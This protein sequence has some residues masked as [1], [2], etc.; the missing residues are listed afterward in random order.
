MSSCICPGYEAVFEC[1]VTGGGATIWSGTALDH[2]TNDRITLRHSYFNQTG[3]NIS[4][5]CGD[6]GQVI[7]CAISAVNDSYTSQ[8][9][10]NISQSL[11]GANIECHVAG[12]N[13]GS[14]I[15][16][17]QILPT[18][19]IAK[20]C[21]STIILCT[22]LLFTAALPPPSNIMLS[23]INS[24]HLTFTWN[25]VSPDCQAVHYLINAT[26]CG[27]C[28]RTTSCAITCPTSTDTNSV[29]CDIDINT[30]TTGLL[31]LETCAVIIQPVVCGN[32]A[33]N[34]SILVYIIL[35]ILCIYIG[36]TG[37]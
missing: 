20:Y 23:K 26:D 6:S 15:G 3:Y 32:V 12:T 28:P 19:G 22:L 1:V 34:S 18:T 27:Q 36:C 2:C 14:Q 30:L 8:L 17:K 31:S 16:T 37:G 7:G 10:I 24:S 21:Q 11:I 13:S 5:P 33:G 29:L 9:I 25:S 4:G 35:L